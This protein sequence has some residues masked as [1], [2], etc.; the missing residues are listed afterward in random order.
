MAITPK[1]STLTVT[2]AGTRVQVTSDT[3][4]RPS[5]AY[6]EAL[7][8]NTGFIYLGLV[9]VTSEIYIVRLSPGQGFSLAGDSQMNQRLGGSGLQLSA[10]YVDSSVSGEKVQMTY[11]YPIGG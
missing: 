7:G 1:H 8:S 5:S 6:F 2:T 9:T 10:L 4:I 3:A 11:M